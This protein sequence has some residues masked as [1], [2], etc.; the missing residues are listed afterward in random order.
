MTYYRQDGKP[1][2]HTVTKPNAILSW[3]L[4][5]PSATPEQRAKAMAEIEKRFAR[6][7]SGQFAYPSD[8]GFTQSSG[9]ITWTPKQ[10]RDYANQQRQKLPDAPF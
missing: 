7:G 4:R 1:T 2:R 10:I 6:R 9:P 3:E 8:Q 5:N